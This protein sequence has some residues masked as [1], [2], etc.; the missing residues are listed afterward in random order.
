[1]NLRLISSLLRICL[2]APAADPED[3]FALPLRVSCLNFPERRRSPH[4][5]AESLSIICEVSRCD[6]DPRFRRTPPS[7][8]PMGRFSATT[9]ASHGQ[10]A[11]S[12][13]RWPPTSSNYRN[14]PPALAWCLDDSR[15]QRRVELFRGSGQDSDCSGTETEVDFGEVT[16]HGTLIR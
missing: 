15:E 10:I 9:T 16:F 12:R 4:S 2:L 11:C 6:A 1:L 13:L 14:T 8:R 3:E 5:G 7:P